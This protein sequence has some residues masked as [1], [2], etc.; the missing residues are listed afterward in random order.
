MLNLGVKQQVRSSEFLARLDDAYR[1]AMDSG[2]W[3]GT[4]AAE[5]VDE[6]WAE[7]AQSWF[8]L[9]DYAIP[10]NGVHNQIDT[11][12][13]LEAYDPALASLIREVFG[14]TTISYTC[15]AVAASADVR[16]EPT[17]EFG[18]DVPHAKQAEIRALFA[19]LRNFFDGYAA[20]KS[21]VDL[22][23]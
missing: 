11:R 13:E 19:D 12:H 3:A 23:L 8:G 1:S 5:N 21:A 15:H 7:G 20:D 9:N 18:D 6:Y 2:L 4:Y 14:D 22:F 10:A 16:K 17:I